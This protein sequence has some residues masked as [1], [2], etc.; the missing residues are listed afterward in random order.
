M[1]LRW[2]M[3]TK[4]LLESV[5]VVESERRAVVGA[6]TRASAATAMI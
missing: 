3:P 6:V 1:R 2:F 5:V 4:V